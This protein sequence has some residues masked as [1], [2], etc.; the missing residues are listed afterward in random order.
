MSLVLGTAG[1]LSCLTAMRLAIRGSEVA[2]PNLE[3]QSVQDATRQLSVS[4]LRLKIDG[5]RFDASTPSDRIISQDPSPNST[6][7]KNRSVRVIVS[8]GAKRVQVPDLRGQ[9]LR[10]GQIALL[11]SGLSLGMIASVN[12]ETNEKDRVISQDPFPQV[13][14]AQTSLVNVLVSSGK[15]GEEYLMPEL[16]G[17]S[18]DEVENA[19]GRL[20]FRLGKVV[21][22]PATGLVKGTVLKQYPS[23]GQKLVVGDSI[24]LE[25]SR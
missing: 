23:P 4:E 5:R 8:L 6:L 13:S 10:V 1:L 12:S 2:I 3:G 15:K 21:Y 20:G 17:G 18:L 9:S 22:Q 11:K 19:C 25:V 16:V 14:E 7:K 24:D